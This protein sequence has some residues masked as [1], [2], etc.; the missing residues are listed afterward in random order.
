MA[1]HVLDRPIWA[2]LTSRQ[3][4]FASGGQDALRYPADVS[5]F[6]V[7]RD[8]SAESL[9]AL[10]ALVPKGGHVITAE[11]GGAP[12]PP[13][14]TLEGEAEIVQM[15]AADP[16]VAEPDDRIIPLGA[17]DA[18]E[19]LALAT[20]TSPGPFAINTHR[21]GRFIGIR[22]DGRLAA[23][24]G[25]RLH[26][27]GY[28]EVSGVCTHPDFQGQGHAGLLSRI[29][30]TRIAREG[31][32][33]FLHAYSSNAVAIRLYEKLGFRIERRAIVRKLSRGE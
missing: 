25:E 30:A 4:H 13:G 9:A 28:R 32:T 17:A 3:A 18:E 23:M 14:L 20:L 33:P 10:A 22:I 1:D 19:M 7:A 29:V 15:L 5:P 8:G 16:A 12:V 11:S 2:A 21:M 26:L 24:A 27:D 6:A 31:E